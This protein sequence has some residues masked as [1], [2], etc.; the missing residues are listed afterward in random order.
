M[1]KYVMK[2]VFKLICVLLSFSCSSESTQG[3]Q[4]YGSDKYQSGVT[5]YEVFSLNPDYNFASWL[6]DMPVSS[7]TWMLQGNIVHISEN[8]FGGSEEI[9]VI[10][11]AKNKATLEF[12]NMS[13]PGVF[14][15]IK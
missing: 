5:S 10:K 12:K 9:K 4:L 7:G 13:K 3:A 14:E 2:Y 8:S 11:I 15:R 1:E 6:P